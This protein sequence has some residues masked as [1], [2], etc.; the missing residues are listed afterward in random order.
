VKLRSHERQS[1]TGWALRRAVV[2]STGTQAQKF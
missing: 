2:A 1:F